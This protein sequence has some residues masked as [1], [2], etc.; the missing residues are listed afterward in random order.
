[1]KKSSFIIMPT[2]NKAVKVIQ[3]N[4]QLFYSFIVLFE[5]KPLP[6]K[7][8]KNFETFHSFLLGPNGAHKATKKNKRAHSPQ[9][10]MWFSLASTPKMPFGVFCGFHTAVTTCSATRTPCGGGWAGLGS[11]FGICSILFWSKKKPG[12]K[13]KL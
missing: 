3:F 7:F 4:F 5:V 2:F 12:K 9:C 13:R 10:F 6:L 1:M 8:L 11:Y